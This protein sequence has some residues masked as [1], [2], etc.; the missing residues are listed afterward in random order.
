MRRVGFQVR[1]R[2]AHAAVE[3]P[4][5]P[6]EHSAWPPGRTCCRRSG[7]EYRIWLRRCAPRLPA[8]PGT[9]APAHRASLRSL[10][11]LGRSPSA[12]PVPRRGAPAPWQARAYA[13][14]ASAQAR[15]RTPRAPFPT[16]LEV[17]AS[18]RDDPFWSSREAFSFDHLVGAS[19]QRRRDFDAECLRG[20]EV[21]RQLELNRLLARQI[22]GGRASQDLL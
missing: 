7:A 18:G 22:C 14:Q 9:P 8:R 16:Q 17:F 1:A 21:Q 10:E 4:R 20:F 2:T 19:E 5:A 12:A 11:G 15:T 13:P 6:A 3:I